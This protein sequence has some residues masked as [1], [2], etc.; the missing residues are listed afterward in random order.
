[1]IVRDL[2]VFWTVLFPDEADPVLIVDAYTVLSCTISSERFQSITRRDPQIIDGR[3]RV[4]KV[5]FP[6]GHSPQRLGTRISRGPGI[7]TVED[8]FSPLILE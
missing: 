1:M 3:H 7:L 5:E 2:Y 4:E 6:V 8:V